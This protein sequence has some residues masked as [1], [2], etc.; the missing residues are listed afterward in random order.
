MYAENEITLMVFIWGCGGLENNPWLFFES[1]RKDNLLEWWILYFA[2]RFF[3]VV[4]VDSHLIR[5]LSTAS[6]RAPALHS[7]LLRPTLACR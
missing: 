3:E 5:I 7:R 1:E 6:N 4:C 2:G